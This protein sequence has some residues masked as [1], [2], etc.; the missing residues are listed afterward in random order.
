MNAD[1]RGPVGKN[2]FNVEFEEPVPESVLS[3]KP[4]YMLLQWIDLSHVRV[5]FKAKP[6]DPWYL[7]KPYNYSQI[8]GGAEL[9]DFLQMD[10]TTSTG[11]AWS[12]YP[13]GSM[14]QKILIDYIHYRY[15]LSA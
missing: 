7:S 11:R 4:V 5:G 1:G 2:V 8:T 13:G 14:Y 15:G 3:H 9:G 10:W 6:D 12:G